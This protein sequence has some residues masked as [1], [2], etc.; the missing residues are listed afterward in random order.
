[1][2]EAHLIT[3]FGKTQLK[4]PRSIRCLVIIRL[5]WEYKKETGSGSSFFVAVLGV[6]KQTWVYHKE[7]K[8]VA[9]GP[10]SEGS[11]MLE[12]PNLA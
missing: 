2:I 11:M 8:Q 7:A 6:A 5:E 1:M 3:A 10:A 4:W 12:G 9:D